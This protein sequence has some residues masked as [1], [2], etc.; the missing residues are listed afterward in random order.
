MNC[1]FKLD[2][3]DM[4]LNLGRVQASL[5]VQQ[6]R[7]KDVTLKEN[8]RIALLKGKIVDGFPGRPGYGAVGEKIIVR[9]NF[10]ELLTNYT[11]G[12][13]EVPIYLYRIAVEDEYNKSFRPIPAERI[14]LH[15]AKTLRWILVPACWMLSSCDL[16]SIDITTVANQ[17]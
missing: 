1:E 8:S 4:Y 5:L 12:K 6:F 15:D 14:T 9:V 3:L 10:Y 7:N 17:L 16:N 13:P 11:Q 2:S